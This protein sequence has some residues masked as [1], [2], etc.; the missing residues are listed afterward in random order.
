MYIPDAE[1][2]QDIKSQ[3]LKQIRIALPYDG[4]FLLLSKRE[5]DHLIETPDCA[6]SEWRALSMMEIF[7]PEHE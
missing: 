2:C 3:A 1:E 6:D 7:A 4:I 5:V